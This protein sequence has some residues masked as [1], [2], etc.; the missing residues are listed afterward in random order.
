MDDEVELSTVPEVELS[1]GPVVEL[2]VELTVV[3]SPSGEVE[4]LLEVIVVSPEEADEASL[5]VSVD[6]RVGSVLS[7]LQPS[8]FSPFNQNDKFVFCMSLTN[9]GN[10]ASLTLYPSQTVPNKLSSASELCSP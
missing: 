3:L 10:Y 8:G 2:V 5:E 7:E 1:T 9:I 6:G 4:L